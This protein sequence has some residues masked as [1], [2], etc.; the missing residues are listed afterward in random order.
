MPD[1]TTVLLSRRHVKDA[2]R[3]PLL[4]AAFTIFLLFIMPGPIL[5]GRIL[6]KR[7]IISSPAT[8]SNAAMLRDIL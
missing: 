2:G 3:S 4:P 5:S 7:A 1:D 8:Y 6:G